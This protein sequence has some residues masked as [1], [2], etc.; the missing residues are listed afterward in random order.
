MFCDNFAFVISTL[1][2]I[3]TF[4]LYEHSVCGMQVTLTLSFLL[5]AISTSKWEDNIPPNHDN[6]HVR[7]ALQ[8]IHENCM[9]NITTADIAD[10]AG[11][12]IGHLHR[13]FPAETGYRPGEYL[14]NLRISKAKSLLMRTDISN[15]S[16]AYRVGISTLQYFSRLFKQQVGVTPQ[17]LR[18]SY[19]LT[20]DYTYRGLY[21]SEDYTLDAVSPREGGSL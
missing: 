11:I 1:Q 3:H 14:T 4:S 18:K 2:N 13:I 21:T 8:Y 20:C 6:K 9:C 17:A 19:N 16:I 7:T 15:T 12:Q 10:A 5:A